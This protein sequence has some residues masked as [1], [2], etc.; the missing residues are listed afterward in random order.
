[1]FYLQIKKN[2]LK[3]SKTSKSKCFE[4]YS[5]TCEGGARLK[6]VEII[7]FLIGSV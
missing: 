6:I 4:R 2:I 1:M 7:N 5:C 3:H